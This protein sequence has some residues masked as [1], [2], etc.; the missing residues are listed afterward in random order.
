MINKINNNNHTQK[1]DYTKQ[2]NDNENDEKKQNKNTR[3]KRQIKKNIFNKHENVDEKLIDD[4]TS[5]NSKNNDA[6]Y[7]HNK[8][9]YYIC[10]HCGATYNDQIAIRNCPC[11][12]K[13][14]RSKR[15]RKI[16]IK[17][18]SNKKKKP[19]KNNIYKNKINAKNDNKNTHKKSDNGCTKYDNSNPNKNNECETFENG[20]NIINE[21][22]IRSTVIEIMQCMRINNISDILYELSKKFP[23]FCFDA[24]NDT[25][26]TTIEE[27]ELITKQNNKK[28]FVNCLNIAPPTKKRKIDEVV[29]K[30]DKNDEFSSILLQNNSE[31]N[32]NNYVNNKYQ[33]EFISDESLTDSYDSDDDI[34][35]KMVNINKNQL[36]TNESDTNVKNSMREN[37]RNTQKHCNTNGPKKRKERK[38]IKN[39]DKTILCLICNK[40][41]ENL[42]SFYNHVRQHNKEYKW[43]CNDCD[44]VTCTK[45]Q[46]QKHEINKHSDYFEYYCPACDIGLT[47]SQYYD[48]P[49]VRE[50]IKAKQ[51]KPANNN[52]KYAK[53][54]RYI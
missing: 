43:K 44:Y 30:N 45:Q 12:K 1:N 40:T 15:K 8:T 17:K 42:G 2:C 23:G 20:Q 47:H 41:F 54:R 50:R 27:F 26:N 29:C 52:N 14:K 46:L 31:I 36:S 48:H 3:D 9:K 21:I 38:Y 35:M 24:Y 22:D 25:I 11:K 53:K 13:K 10:K 32:N 28:R 18:K 6:K 4:N 19:N 7:T 37:I 33:N 34:I 16:K 5:N 49:C 39:N 51:K